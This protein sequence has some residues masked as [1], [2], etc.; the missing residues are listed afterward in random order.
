M[1]EISISYETLFD[2]LR[3]E[4]N[5]AE[6]QQLPMNFYKLVSEYVS[7]VQGDK[8][9]LIK[10]IAEIYERRERKIINCALVAAQTN[11]RPSLLPEEGQL[12][13]QLTETIIRFRKENISKLLNPAS[14]ESVNTPETSKTSE[15]EETEESADKG[16]NILV[17]FIRPVPQF[18]G[19]SLE[20]YGPFESEDMAN[21]P[22][23]I[24]R[25]LIQKERAVRV[26]IG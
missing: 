26:R 17:R 20:V 18:V 10:I 6:L 16:E 1:A 12:F 4:K 19:K 14:A 13:E 11:T 5:K 9:N 23:E 2:I 7:S 25:V 22:A 24:A 8:K 3:N 15:S 21:L